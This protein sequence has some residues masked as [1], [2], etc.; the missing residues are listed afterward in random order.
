MIE[1]I[2]LDRIGATSIVDNIVAT[3]VRWLG[4]TEN[5]GWFVFD[6]RER[7]R[8]EQPIYSFQLVFPN[9]FYSKYNG[10]KIQWINHNHESLFI[11]LII[12]IFI[13]LKKMT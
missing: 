11:Y 13:L 3:R 12:R 9:S 6:F 5:V 10:R 7:N 8:K 2:K 1:N 4:Y